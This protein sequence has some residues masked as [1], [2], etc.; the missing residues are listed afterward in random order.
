MSSD[1]L[2]LLPP[3]LRDFEQRIGLP[4]T[5]ALVNRW[6]GLRVYFPTPDR[7]SVEHPIAQVIGLDKLLLLAEQYGG[8]EHRQLP[9]ARQA[10]LALRNARIVAARGQKSARDLAMEHGLT[11]GQII[12]VWAAAGPVTEDRQAELFDQLGQLL[13]PVKA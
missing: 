6:G 3:L 12:R 1:T 2:A 11:E 8:N 13:G 7:C 4:A 5:L 10:L 9:K